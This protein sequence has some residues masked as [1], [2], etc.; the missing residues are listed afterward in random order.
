MC[1]VSF[2]PLIDSFL[3]PAVVAQWPWCSAADSDIAG[4]IPGCSSH[5]SIRA[6]C[7][8]HAHVPRIVHM[9]KN[10]TPHYGIAYTVQCWDVQPP[11][12]YILLVLVLVECPSHNAQAANYTFVEYNLELPG[13][14]LTLSDIRASTCQSKNNSNVNCYLRICTCLM[15]TMNIKEC[16]SPPTMA[17]HY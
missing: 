7:K 4:S 1:E 2:K 16:G 8:E 5:I 12:L 15:F 14:E 11:T 17:L 6:E 10:T 9:L 13:R 3:V